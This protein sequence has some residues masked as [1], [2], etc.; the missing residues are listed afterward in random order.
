MDF[1]LNAEQK[2]LQDAVR[3]FL[4]KEYPRE[5]IQ[6]ILETENGYSH[7]L[8]KK[9]AELGWLG[10]VIPEENG[11]EGGSFL[12][13]IIL[14]EEMGYNICPSPFFSS[15][16][17]AGL[18]ILN[19][20]SS[21]QKKEL[22]PLIAS[23][24]KI[25]TLAFLEPDLKMESSSMN[26]TA[27]LDKDSYLLQGSKLFVPYAHVSDFILCVAKTREDK[28]P[29]E[30]ISL[31]LIDTNSSDF[32]C[33][34]LNTLGLEKYFALR[35]CN[36]P[37]HRENIIGPIHEAWPSIKDVLAKASLCLSA[38]MIGGARA[39]MDMS[40]SYAKERKQFNR[41]IG[42]FQAI[43]QYL[44]DMWINIYATHYLVYRA[45]WKLEQNLEAEKEIAAAKSKAGE[46][47]RRSTALGH[48]ILGAIGFTKESDMHLYH[49]SSMSDYL[50]FGDSD[51]QK[52]FIAKKL[53][54]DNIRS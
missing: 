21:R 47:Y 48:Q 20:A 30:S 18:T 8:W 41:A 39:V 33:D 2:L 50:N 51:F 43:Q 19:H 31:F 24:E 26:T 16:V 7:K 44:V 27:I 3:E 4:K 11:G 32:D 49:R 6:E 23:G 13:L 45:A 17:L 15:V 40:L 36:T 37:I 5:I 14:L 28:N 46:V 25:F 38:R 54:L 52:E 9:M 10:I 42:S 53:E 22:L 12:E 35:F 34:L 1:E 29:D